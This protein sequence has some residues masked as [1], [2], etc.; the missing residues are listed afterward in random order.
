MEL[1]SLSLCGLEQFID[2]CPFLILFSSPTVFIFFLSY[3]FIVFAS[4]S[5]PI[6]VL[7][8]KA[9]VN[10]HFRSYSR[11][12][13]KRVWAKEKGRQLGRL[14]RGGNN[15]LRLLAGLLRC[16]ADSKKK[17]K[18]NNNNLTRLVKRKR[19]LS[20]VCSESTSRQVLPFAVKD[21]ARAERF[22]W[23][24]TF[25]PSLFSLHLFY[26]ATATLKPK[27]QHW[28]I[29]LYFV[30]SE[31]NLLQKKKHRHLTRAFSLCYSTTAGIEKDYTVIRLR[32]ARQGK[33]K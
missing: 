17:R 25:S 3:S 21:L 32:Q 11:C 18:I 27:K 10:S 23:F 7:I 12:K 20:C 4:F 28:N 30:E 31:I 13:G 19:C 6:A 5:M 33:E 16:V 14:M 29:F 8:D 2:S 26:V 9:K 1:T 22:K 24:P 15:Q